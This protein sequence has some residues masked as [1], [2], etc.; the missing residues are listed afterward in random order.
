MHP[1]FYKKSP[2]KRAFLFVLKVNPVLSRALSAQGL[3][4]LDEVKVS[5]SFVGAGVTSSG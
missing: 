2:R 5:Q 3:L 4:H 1:F